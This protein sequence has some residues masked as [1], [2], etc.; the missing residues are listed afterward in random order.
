MPTFRTLVHALTALCLLAQ[1]VL[2]HAAMNSPEPAETAAQTELPPCHGGGGESAAPPA[3]N[4]CPDECRCT[5]AC[6]SMPVLLRLTA[7]TVTALVAAPATA[8]PA[9]DIL[10]A[11][12][13]T[14]LRPPITLQN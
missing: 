10:P 9:A 13:L 5:V 1:P 14:L 4:C 3:P 7:P 8:L 6:G 2:A 11:H 12:T